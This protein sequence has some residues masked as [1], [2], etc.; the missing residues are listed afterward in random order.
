MDDLDGMKLLGGMLNIIRDY[1]MKLDGEFATLLTNMMVL[2][3][4]AKDV[5]PDINILKCAIPYFSYVKDTAM[6]E[7][8]AEKE[9]I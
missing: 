7:S 9:I 1:R 6:V 3:A 4:M 8:I 5:D 2:E